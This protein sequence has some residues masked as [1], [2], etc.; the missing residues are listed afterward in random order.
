M[1]TQTPQPTINDAVALLGLD[2][3]KLTELAVE[4][5]V[6]SVMSTRE[7]GDGETYECGSTF[8]REIESRV[9]KVV[10]TKLEL[11]CAEQ[12][13]P[14]VNRMID[15]AIL[16]ETTKYG[17]TL[18]RPVTFKEYIAKRADEY[19]KEPV[20]WQ[21]NAKRERKDPYGWKS[22]QTRI[23]HLVG[24]K[25]QDIMENGMKDAIK[26]LVASLN[27]SLDEQVKREM[28]AISSKVKVSFT[29]R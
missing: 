13:V 17:E 19:L 27:E 29:G 14:Y 1:D 10:D 24:K 9:V 15:E 7:Y 16:Q 5:I 25:L 21:G 26:Q 2:R 23:V 8:Q 3:E 6:D 22:D 28:A 11:I 20:D 4:Q 12:V 18:G